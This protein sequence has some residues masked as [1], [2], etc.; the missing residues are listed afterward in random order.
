MFG[1]VCADC[2]GSGTDVVCADYVTV[3]GA[4]EGFEG[5]G[6]PVSVSVVVA[7]TLPVFGKVCGDGTRGHFSGV[8]DGDECSGCVVRRIL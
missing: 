4:G 6:L 7:G 5:G 8:D 1:A 2:V 3:V